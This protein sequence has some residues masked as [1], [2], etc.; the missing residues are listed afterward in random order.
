MVDILAKARARS[1]YKE[2]TAEMGAATRRGG[3]G[4]ALTQ[5]ALT[6][7]IGCYVLGHWMMHKILQ[8]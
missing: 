6:S 7:A 8:L 1:K 3:V 5:M 4:M 2:L